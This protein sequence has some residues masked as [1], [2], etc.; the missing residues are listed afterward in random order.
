MT[1]RFSIDSRGLNLLGISAAR[2]RGSRRKEVRVLRY[3]LK[4]LPEILRGLINGNL[5]Q[6]LGFETRVL[7][8]RLYI[9]FGKIKVVNDPP[10]TMET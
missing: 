4:E 5:N 9:D 8:A 10:A 6:K 1:H 3:S 2:A 7:L